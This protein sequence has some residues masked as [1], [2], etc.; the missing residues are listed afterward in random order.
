MLESAPALRHH[1]GGVLRAI[2]SSTF[3]FA[4]A[5]P[6]ACT[7]GLTDI[8]PLRGQGWT[9]WLATPLSGPVARGTAAAADS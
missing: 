1:A 7:A 3:N 5:V 6:I 4:T 2:M 9:N 8:L